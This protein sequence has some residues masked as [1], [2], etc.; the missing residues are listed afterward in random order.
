MIKN[1]KIP[2][3]ILCGGKGSRF[4]KLSEMPKQLSLLN[5][6]PLIMHIIDHFYNSGLNFIIL[7][8]GFKKKMFFK[9]FKSKIN[10]KKYK[11]NLIK[12]IEE[13]SP[14][15]KNIL[16]FDA[17][18][19][20]NKLER[21]RKS[22]KFISQDKFIATYGDGI[23]NVNIKSLLKFSNRSACVVTSYKTKSQYGHIIMDKKNILK[24]FVEKPYLDNPINIGFYVFKKNIILKN[25]SKKIDLEDGLLPMLLKKI[26][27]YSYLHKGYFYSVDNAKDLEE[28]R[29]KYV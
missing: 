23:S 2:V 17:K 27:I 15:Y 28:L 13:I 21:I 9:F 12:K 19:R 25:F 16:L 4:S 5:G 20:S 26:N 14:K 6:K 8:L 22:L 11:F 18:E 24:K 29:K 10:K 3:V 1:P 7:P